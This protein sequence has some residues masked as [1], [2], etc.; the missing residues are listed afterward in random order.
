MQNFPYFIPNPLLFAPLYAIIQK[1]HKTPMMESRM[2]SKKQPQKSWR[3]RIT[4]YGTENPQSL[5]PNPLNYR[6]HPKHQQDA[7]SGV[8]DDV[9]LV[10]NIIVNRRT[11]ED[12]PEGERNVQ[13]V[14]DGHLRIALAIEHGESEI[15]VT[16]VDLTKK[17]ESL[18]LATIDPLSSLAI[19]DHDKL[20]D[21]LQLVN[22]DNTSIMEMLSDLSGVPG[23]KSDNTVVVTGDSAEI[24]DGMITCPKCGHKWK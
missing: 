6:I 9:G 16:Y 8:L 15:P 11:G 22:T 19:V 23:I 1:E 21:L 24:E 17:E 2:P 5:I 3:L 18:I 7:L 12:W 13:T 10:Q 4:G 20:E 14:I